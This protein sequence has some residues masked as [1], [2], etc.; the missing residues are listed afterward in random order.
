MSARDGRVI[1]F[2]QPD[3][4]LD[5][6]QVAQ[7]LKLRPRRSARHH[8]P[9]LQD[10]ARLRDMLLARMHHAALDD[11]Q[12]DFVQI[13][14]QARQSHERHA[15]RRRAANLDAHPLDRQVLG[16]DRA[17]VPRGLRGHVHPQNHAQ[18]PH[19][20]QNA[21]NAERIRDGVAIA[22]D[23][24]LLQRCV[25]RC[26]HLL[27]GV[28]RRRVGGRAGEQAGDDAEPYVTL[29]RHTAPIV[30]PRPKSKAQ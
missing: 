22:G 27:A 14:Q 24:D 17:G 12:V 23:G 7:L 18:Q 4:R 1:N 10:V 5:A 2:V 13:G 28:K 16:G 9:G 6:H 20:Q 19:R 21:G 8:V 26:Q 25:Q 3:T 29:S 15:C 11:A 30:R